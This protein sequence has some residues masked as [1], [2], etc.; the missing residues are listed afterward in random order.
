[1]T[2]ITIV[3]EEDLSGLDAQILINDLEE[4]VGKR[5]LTL[6]SADSDNI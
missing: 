4:V 6:Y 2:E 3:V 1:M 5:N